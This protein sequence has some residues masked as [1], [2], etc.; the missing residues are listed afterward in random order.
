[1]K[2][3][4]RDLFEIAKEVDMIAQGCNCFCVQGA[5]I[6]KIF[7]EKF[8]TSKYKLESD[9]H[10]GKYNKLGNIDFEEKQYGDN[11]LL[12]AN[13][14]TQYKP[15]AD[16]DYV[17]LAMVFKKL[18]FLCASNNWSLAIPLIGGGIA[19]GD[20]FKII[21]IMKSIFKKT[22]VTLCLDLQKYKEYETG[23]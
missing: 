20:L 21:N 14:Y 16:L 8:E 18:E 1:M 17:A 9:F 11:K 15:G 12:V 2:I 19:G 3:V 22:D 23:I 7:N 10:K 4:N 6:S 13:T 5:G